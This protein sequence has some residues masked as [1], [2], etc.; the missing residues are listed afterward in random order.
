MHS[1]LRIPILRL[2]VATAGRLR[3]LTRQLTRSLVRPSA[4]D[5]GDSPVPTAIIIAGLA[6]IAIGVLAWLVTYVEGFMSDAPTEL[7]EGPEG[8]G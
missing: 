6:V 1:L 5:R 3:Q 2:H 4:S 8:P 7:P